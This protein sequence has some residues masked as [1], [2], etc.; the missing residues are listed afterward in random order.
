MSVW[1]VNILEYGES[2]VLHICW[3]RKIAIR[4][5][6]KEANK[7]RETIGLEPIEESDIEYLPCF[8]HGAFPVDICS[9]IVIQ[10]QEMLME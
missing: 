3:T 6:L 4:E 2:D 7:T 1:L 8:P 5:A 9:W 10:S